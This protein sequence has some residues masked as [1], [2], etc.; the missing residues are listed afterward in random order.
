MKVIEISS[1]R[2]CP[3]REMHHCKRISSRNEYKPIE[4]LDKIPKWCPLK[5]LIDYLI[6]GLS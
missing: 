2:G 6:K 1:C 4:D 3:N 5:D